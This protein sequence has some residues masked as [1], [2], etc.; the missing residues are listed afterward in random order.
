MKSFKTNTSKLAKSFSLISSA[1]V[2]SYFPTYF[3]VNVARHVFHRVVRK[4]GGRMNDTQSFTAR[5]ATSFR[6]WLFFLENLIIFSLIN[7][8]MLK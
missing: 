7:E 1:L 3:D 4:R 8:I 2:V 6:K 5:R